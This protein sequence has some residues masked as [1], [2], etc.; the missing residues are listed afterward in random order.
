M[1]FGFFKNVNHARVLMDLWHEVVVFLKNRN[2]VL[3][4][5]TA[6]PEKG[7]HSLCSDFSRISIIFMNIFG[8]LESMN[9]TYSSGTSTI[10]EKKR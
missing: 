7:T 3:H 4:C 6:S 1:L 9:Y 8:K 2:N 5:S 10:F